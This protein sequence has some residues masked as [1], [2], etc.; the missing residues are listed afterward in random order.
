MIF[1]SFSWNLKKP[2]EYFHIAGYSL[3]YKIKFSQDLNWLRKLSIRREAE[4]AF[5]WLVGENSTAHH[6]VE[7]T[8][9]S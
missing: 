8:Y 1:F 2:V 3:L 5:Q 7:P 6:E 9:V 4:A